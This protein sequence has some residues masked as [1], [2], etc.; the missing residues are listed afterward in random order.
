MQ[1]VAARLTLTVLYTGGGSIGI[2]PCRGVAAKRT[3]PSQAS[4]C[5]GK[6]IEMS[7][8]DLVSFPNPAGA[9]LR[10]AIVNWSVRREHAFSTGRR[11]TGW[12]RCSAEYLPCV[13]TSNGVRGVVAL[14]GVDIPTLFVTVI[15]LCL[16]VGGCGRHQVSMEN[17]QGCPWHFCDSQLVMQGCSGQGWQVV[18][19]L[20]AM[21][22]V[23]LHVSMVSWHLCDSQLVMQGCSGQGWQVVAGAA[24]QHGK[25]VRVSP[26][27]AWAGHGAVHPLFGCC[28][29]VGAWCG[30]AGQHVKHASVA[31]G[32]GARTSVDAADTF[33]G[34]LGNSVPVPSVWL[35]YGVLQSLR[36]LGFVV[37]LVVAYR[38]WHFRVSSI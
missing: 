4:V 3:P 29:C 12:V 6:G 27:A 33:L 15:D 16:L 19:G 20:G 24:G 17:M 18:V 8:V 30:A 32:T 1:R 35:S 25:H 5:G 13:K 38:H 36:L 28:G 22:I 23:S 14:G 21:S 31:L 34:E 26:A 9:F 11:V 37:D 7:A 2:M 10:S